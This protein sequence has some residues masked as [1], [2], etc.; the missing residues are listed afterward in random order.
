M[1]VSDIKDVLQRGVHHRKLNATALHKQPGRT[2]SIITLNLIVKE[3][4][5]MGVEAVRY[6]KLN[7]VDLAR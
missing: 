4:D 2:H 6:G 5:Q 7:F 3:C 1:K